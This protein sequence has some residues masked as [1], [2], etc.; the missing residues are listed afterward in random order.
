MPGT[1]PTS[2]TSKSSRPSICP[3]I[4]PSSTPS[5]TSSRPL[6]PT[7]STRSSQSATFNPAISSTPQPEN[8]LSGLVSKTPHLGVIGCDDGQIGAVRQLGSRFGPV[9][10]KV[11][12]SASFDEL[13][14]FLAR[15][16]ELDHVPGCASPHRAFPSPSVCM[17]LGIVE[18]VNPV[19][20][21]CRSFSGLMDARLLLGDR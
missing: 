4:D 12:P 18:R 13:V 14:Q 2:A 21:K 9:R 15:G 7:R 19:A 20:E 17:D 1:W 5:F 6:P 11:P 8:P 3:S 16:A 10:I